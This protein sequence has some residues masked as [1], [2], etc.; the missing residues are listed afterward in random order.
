MPF[1]QPTKIKFLFMREPVKD[2]TRLEHTLEAI[3]SLIENKDKYTLEQIKSDKILFFGFVKLLE[4]IGEA[5][6]MLTKEFRTAH[7]ATN[8]QVIE[9][10][11][12]VLVHGYYTISADILWRTIQED[13]VPLKAQIKQYIK[14]L[15]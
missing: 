12:H 3:N 2:I 11:R 15:S 10:M 5:T 7:T 6:Y 8:W 9:N 4:I 1:L 13:I 14:E